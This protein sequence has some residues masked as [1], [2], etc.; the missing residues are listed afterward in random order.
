MSDADILRAKVVE[1]ISQ[2][3]LT[4]ELDIDQAVAVLIGAFERSKAQIASPIPAEQWAEI[5]H[6]V[7]MDQDNQLRFTYLKG[8]YRARTLN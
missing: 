7:M 2:G 3:D 4:P 5:F 1:W 6:K 8:T